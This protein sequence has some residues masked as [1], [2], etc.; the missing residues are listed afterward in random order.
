MDRDHLRLSRI[1]LLEEPYPNWFAAAM[2]RIMPPGAPP[3]KLFRAIATSQRAWDKFAAG[4]LLD[5]GP[6]PLRER[7]I[8][9]LRTCARCGC[10]YE[11]GIH[12]ALFAT[13]AGLSEA[14]LADTAATAIDP[15]LWS[16]AEAALLHSVDALADRKQ[17]TDMEFAALCAYFASEQILEI[18]QLVAFYTGVSII[19]GA[20]DLKPEAGT[21]A[22]PQGATA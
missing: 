15:S 6:L 11:W 18:I 4:S 19:C 7:G 9:I 20:L 3:L 5:K 13:R 2:E 16:G 22:L 21:P 14:Q 10:G 12:A 8:V 1:G 17:L